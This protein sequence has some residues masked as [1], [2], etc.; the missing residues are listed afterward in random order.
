M[1]EISRVTK[2]GPDQEIGSERKRT[3]EGERE[4]EAEEERNREGRERLKK[5]RRIRGDE[6]RVRLVLSL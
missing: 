2:T 6:R 1:T 4:G 5:R 3:R